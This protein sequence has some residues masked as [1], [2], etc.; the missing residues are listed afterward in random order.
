MKPSKDLA[1]SHSLNRRQD[2]KSVFSSFNSSAPAQ[3]LPES[4]K[5]SAASTGNG[6]APSHLT[7]IISACSRCRSRKIKCDQKFPSCSACLKSGVEC[8]GLDAATGREVPRSYI[9]HLEE[10][11]AFLEIQLQNQGIPIDNPNSSTG[12]KSAPSTNGSKESVSVPAKRAALSDSSK[13]V[14]SLVSTVGLVSMKG[15]STL[16]SPSYLGLS[17]GISFARLMFAAVKLRG[18]DIPSAAMSM[19]SSEQPDMTIRRKPV[20]IQ[21]A[22]LPSKK[23]AETL[24]EDFFNQA[25]AQI[26]IFHRN[27]FIKTYFEPVYGPYSVQTKLANINNVQN[28]SPISHSA[29]PDHSQSLRFSPTA[30]VKAEPTPNTSIPAKKP[31]GSA[32]FTVPPS[33]SKTGTNSSYSRSSSDSPETHRALFFLNLIFAIGV[34]VHQQQYPALLCESYHA[35]AMRYIEPVFASV[36]RLESLQGILLLGL[37]SIMRPAVPGVWYVLGV[38]L[39]LCVDL[40]LHVEGGVKSW[41][42]TNITPKS[43]QKESSAPF[44]ARTLDLR[45]R[46]FWCTYAMDRQ[47]GVYL[48]RP[49]GIAD[50]SIKVP[51]P[52]D[53]DD[54]FI[55]SEGIIDP[56]E[57]TPPSYKQVAVHIFQIR[58]LQS[59][60]QTILYERAELPRRFATLKEWQNNMS[61]RLEE[62]HKSAPKSS[63]DMNCDFN[64]SF[65]D[66]NYQ[67]T[68]LLLHGISPAIPRPSVEAFFIIA[69]ASEQVIRAYRQLHR[70]KNI[71]YTWMA[72]HNL[73][74]AGTSYLYCLYHSKEVRSRTRMDVIDFNTMACIHVLS[75]MVDKCDAASGCRDTFELLTA[76]I[77]R[78]C[79]NEKAASGEII[80]HPGPSGALEYSSSA[81][82]RTPG[83][84]GRM[85]TPPIPPPMPPPAK[86]SRKSRSSASSATVANSAPSMQRS[87]AEPV[88]QYP[89]MVSMGPVPTV[90]SVEF[91]NGNGT[92]TVPP[93]TTASSN[94]IITPLLDTGTENSQASTPQSTSS[95][96]ESLLPNGSASVGTTGNA[97]SPFASFET[98]TLQWMT[99][100]EPDLDEIFK[101]AA[102]IQAV[103]PMHDNYTHPVAYSGN[104]SG[105]TQGGGYAYQFSPG[106][107]VQQQFGSA[108]FGAGMDGSP[109]DSTVSATS[110]SPGQ[111]PIWPRQSSFSI[112]NGGSNLVLATSAPTGSA[113]STAT[114]GVNSQGNTPPTTVLNGSSPPMF[115]SRSNSAGALP[116][117]QPA[118]GQTQAQMIFDDEYDG[119]RIYEMMNE[120]P[121]ASIWEQFCVMPPNNGLLGF[122]PGFGTMLG[123]GGEQMIGGN[124][125]PSPAVISNQGVSPSTNGSVTGTT[126]TAA[127]T[128]I[129]SVEG[130]TYGGEFFA[131]EM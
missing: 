79:Y 119:Q 9:A 93:I 16:S 48:G 92:A 75:A 42:G 86:R 122:G 54:V 81:E 13:D 97:L 47:V 46:L 121:S 96:T 128:A 112:T 68:R 19:A 76:A 63:K 56:P 59:E 62:W 102:E 37:Y 91:S 3:Q 15:S 44:D 118:T 24:I 95:A 20:T 14:D 11:V 2:S 130:G 114:A 34:S 111:T 12:I 72:V 85:A 126:P 52:S 8:V 26:P 28:D 87:N 69:D 33:D 98:N 70:E 74:M 18:Q 10:R 25:N 1:S 103:P 83:A 39:R 116:A 104:V 131:R 36:E 6:P 67:Q 123:G 88:P 4:M 49:F 27:D 55:T 57:N 109:G 106:A 73:F 120:L 21:P 101:T 82:I 38:A 78:L 80:A 45:R 29:S 77:L 17:S 100:M 71:N 60:V 117:G 66:L 22:P 40:G 30:S 53:L 43:N 61:R 94:S 50:C 32:G 5:T 7:R 107:A 124:G 58:R 99:E 31:S 129:V 35:T 110:T 108:Y 41:S 90:A 51:F 84:P 127:G 89:Q 105:N 113:V 23:V 115:S 65:L 125:T 64:L